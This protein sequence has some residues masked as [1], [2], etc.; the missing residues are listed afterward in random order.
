MRLAPSIRRLAAFFCLLMVLLAALTPS[1]ASHTFAILVVLWFIL[2]L[3]IFV[4][5]ADV[6]DDNHPHQAPLIAALSPRAPPTL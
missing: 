3:S 2:P 1:V 5:W 6:S 4:Q